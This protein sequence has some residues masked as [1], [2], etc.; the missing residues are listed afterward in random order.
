MI[1]MKIKNNSLKLTAYSFLK[2]F[3]CFVLITFVAAGCSELED[4]GKDTYSGYDSPFEW[5]ITIAYFYYYNA[6]SGL[7]ELELNDNNYDGNIDAAWDFDHDGVTGALT[8]YDYD[9]NNDGDNDWVGEYFYVNDDL[10][11]CMERLVQTRVGGPDELRWEYTFDVDCNRLTYVLYEND[12]EE[13][14]GTYIRD[15]DGN[16]LEL[17]VD[18]L[19]T[20]YYT[21]GISGKP[22]R[23]EYDHGSNWS[24]DRVGTYHYDDENNPDGK[25][26]YL[27][28]RERP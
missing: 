26:L 9:E 22:L 21:L 4:V 1:K 3:I 11:D 6:V 24:I 20:W 25:L 5:P 14:S 13:E 28:S 12:V 10:T 17:E 27:F 15:A 23:Y 18:T 8:G 16:L 7:L 2:Y 19:G